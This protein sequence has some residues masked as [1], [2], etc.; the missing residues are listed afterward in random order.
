MDMQGHS[1]TLNP[2][3]S[4]SGNLKALVVDATGRV[5]V[6]FQGT[7]I[8]EDDWTVGVHELIPQDLGSGVTITQDYQLGGSQNANMSYPYSAS[9]YNLTTHQ[10]PAKSVSIT[11]S[12]GDN[13][14]RL[15]WVQGFD[16]GVT[17]NSQYV[18][19]DYEM[20]PDGSFTLG[21]TTPLSPTVKRQDS[22]SILVSPGQPLSFTLSG[23]TGVDFSK[24]QWD[25]GD[26]AIHTATS[27]SASSTGL[28]ANAQHVYDQAPGQVGPSASYNIKITNLPENAHDASLPLVVMDTQDGGLY[29]KEIWNGPHIITGN[30]IVPSGLSLAVGNLSTN[31]SV[32]Y[33]GG[34]EA[35]LVQGIT[36]QGS[37]TMGNASNPA[38]TVQ[39]DPT[40]PSLTGQTWGTIFVTGTATIS[41]AVIQGGDRG[42]TAAPGSTVTLIG[43]QLTSNLIGFHV[44][45]P[46]VATVSGCLF[47]G[48]TAY[49]VKEDSSAHPVLTNNQFSL[50][51][52]DYYEDGVGLIP[53]KAVNKLGTNS[54][55][56]G[57]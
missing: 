7:G 21:I 34:I 53:L 17:L 30:V 13:N 16:N 37:L 14:I 29:E 36:V 23:G 28:G 38:I 35:S 33:S 43:D 48:N 27:T 18:D 24:V 12:I 15:Q 32:T 8:D 44:V 39:T 31:T 5:Q 19:L 9:T 55:N 57:Q 6:V 26:E 47:T 20:Q 10:Y 4:T 52:V 1:I 54:G 46:S 49:G 50:N 11:L 56:A 2:N 25:F 51:T 3:G 41:N 40:N 42:V 22:G 45:G